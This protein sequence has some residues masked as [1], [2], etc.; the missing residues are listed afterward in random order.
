MICSLE[1]ELIYQNET[2]IFLKTLSGIG[3]KV[4]FNKYQL[5]LKKSYFLYTAQTFRENGQDLY[6]FETVKDLEMFDLL[7]SV[8]GVGSK[9]AFSLVNSLGY[10][11]VVQAIT[12]ENKTLLSTAPG[13]GKK[14]A[15]QIILDLSGK[16]GKL[17]WVNS[18]QVNSLSELG[19]SSAQEFAKF[20]PNNNTV[21][22]DAILA[23]KELGFK[24]SLVVTKIN[25][26]MSAGVINTS[27]ELIQKV[28]KEL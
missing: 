12:M 26:I 3:Y 25:E 13:I 17:G 20:G 18:G 15:S 11:T 14:A 16:L 19:S 2:H 1:G 5:E 21:I 28:L 8:K 9:S 23:C 27:E 10:E 24:D 4:A 7:C 6:G 22:E